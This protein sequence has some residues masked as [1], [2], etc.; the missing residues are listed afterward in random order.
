MLPGQCSAQPQGQREDLARRL[1]GRVRQLRQGR[2]HDDDRVEVAVGRVRDGEHRHV[3]PYGDRPDLP[4][5]LRE[6]GARHRDVLD[7]RPPQ[8]L[9]RGQR[10]PPRGRQ[11]LTSTGSAAVST[12]AA[13]GAT[14]R[15]TVSA[16]TAAPAPSHCT[17][18]LAAVGPAPDGL[19]PY[20][21]LP[22]VTPIPMSALALPGADPAEVEAAFEDVRDLLR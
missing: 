6:A 21:G 19:V 8:P 14:A 9:H 3:V 2:V 20:D 13:S 16:S 4:D 12:V 1:P 11:G 10:Q 15:A 18:L 5:R 17:T 7:Q 22:P